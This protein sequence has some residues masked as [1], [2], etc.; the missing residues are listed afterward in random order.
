[1]KRTIRRYAGVL[2]FAAGI[3]SADSP[4][5]FIPIILLAAGMLILKGVLQDE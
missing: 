5:L 1:M 4:A 2:L 3:A